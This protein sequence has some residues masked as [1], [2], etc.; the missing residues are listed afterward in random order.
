MESPAV[1][2]ED[3]TVSSATVSED[4]FSVRLA[5]EG[6]REGYIHEVKLGE[7]TSES[8]LSLLHDRAFYTLNNIPESGN[9]SSEMS[10]ESQQS[11]LQNAETNQGTKRLVTMPD[12]WAGEADFSLSIGHRTRVAI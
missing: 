3:L 4:G 11:G 10:G 7:L 12:G 9:L 1:N 5:V 6:L 2:I 8:A